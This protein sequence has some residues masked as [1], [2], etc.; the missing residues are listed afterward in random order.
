[1]C[2][3][4]D[5]ETCPNGNLYRII[6]LF[7]D[8][9]D[10]TYNIKLINNSSIGNDF[11]DYDDISFNSLIDINNDNNKYTISQMNNILAAPE[12]PSGS[13]EWATA[14][15]N[16]YINNDLFW[17]NLGEW[18]NMIATTSWI[19][20]GNS[21]DNISNATVKTTFQNEIVSP[22]ANTSFSGKIGLMYVSD[23]GYAAAPSNWTTELNN[24]ESATS[25]NWLYLGSEEWTIS[26]DTSSGQ[27]VFSIQ[28]NGEIWFHFVS[29][30]D[31]SPNFRACFY[32]I[33]DLILEKGLGTVSDP[34]R[35]SL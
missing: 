32:L 24:Y 18:Q 16:Y 10:G 23:Y 4:S 8:D 6:G 28:S 12:N 7:D 13:N 20:G 2:F 25:T 35:L 27:L 33:D 14:D 19:V 17:N 31:S 30:P 1:M 11:F 22:V 9:K 3:G 26:K 21:D 34:Y 5:E 15:I 29:N